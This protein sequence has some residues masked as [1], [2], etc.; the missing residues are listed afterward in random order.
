MK[1]VEKTHRC[2]Y[3]QCVFFGAS[4]KLARFAENSINIVVSAEQQTNIFK[5]VFKTGPRLC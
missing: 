5:N 4:F 1:N 3:K 2:A